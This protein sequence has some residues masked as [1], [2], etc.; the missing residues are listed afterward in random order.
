M[1]ETMYHLTLWCPRSKAADL[2]D[3]LLADGSVQIQS[4]QDDARLDEQSADLVASHQKLRSILAALGDDAASD[5]STVELLLHQFEKMPERTRQTLC[6]NLDSI[7][8]TIEALHA[9][10]AFLKEERENLVQSLAVAGRPHIPD[11]ADRVRSLWWVS[12]ESYPLCRARLN[13]AVS[14]LLERADDAVAYSRHDCPRS[15]LLL[16]E[17]A[18][19]REMDEMGRSVLRSAGARQW[20]P[21]GKFEK[22]NYGPASE[23]MEMEIRRLEAAA[24][25]TSAELTALGRKWG[26]KLAALSFLT[27]RNLAV[28]R[29]LLRCRAAGTAVNLEGWLPE[30][31]LK[32]FCQ[33]IR[34]KFGDSVAL[35]LRQPTKEEMPSVPTALRQSPPVRPFALFLQLVRPPGYG[36]TDPTAAISL[37]FPFFAGCIVG[38]IGY[39]AVMLLLLWVLCRCQK[40]PIFKDLRFILS[41]VAV[42]GIIWGVAFGECFGDMGHR[43]FGLEP[44][45]VERGH[46]VMPVLF[47][48]LVMGLGHVLLGLG[49]GVFQSLRGGHRHHAA[50]KAGLIVVILSVLICLAPAGRLLPKSAVYWGLGGCGAG[51]LLLTAGG[52]IGG[53]VESFSAFG[54][55]LSYVRIGAIGLSS[56]ILAVTASKFLDT[57]GLTAVGILAALAIHTLNFVMAFAESGL[58][59]ARLHYVEFMGKFYDSSGKQFTPFT[60]RRFHSWKKVS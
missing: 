20:L 41:A 6:G 54:N 24:S 21:P 45:W 30:S 13:E 17:I 14:G 18:L 58:H 16:V 34:E 15:D 3:F 46:A 38:D 56:A 39:S 23:A 5:G 49:Y 19:P 37:F 9:R 26:P 51:F 2:L 28:R 48:S 57:F 55:I 11:R 4:D 47:A 44:L 31:R 7:G 10:L 59:A 50:E 43:L 27:E 12:F 53:I 1:I 42:W 32:A 25:E 29:A 33:S 52:G 8:E 40:S 36:S 35:T 22:L 60:D